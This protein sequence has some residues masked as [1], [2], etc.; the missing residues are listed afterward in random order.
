MNK[1]GLLAILVVF[2]LAVGGLWTT[3][4]VNDWE[5]QLGLD[6]QGG[7]SLTLE[8]APGQGEIDLEVLDQTVE[9]IRNRVDGLGVAEPEIARQGETVIVQ[10]PGVADQAQAEDIVQETAILQFRRV[11]RE[12]RPTDPDYD[13][14]GPSCAELEE[15]RLAG[16]P[17]A[18]EEVV[19]CQPPEAEAGLVD[20]PEEEASPTEEWTKFEL[21]P[22]V[23]DGGNVEDAS[24]R[25]GETGLEWATTLDF[26][27]EGEETFREFTAE[28]ACEQGDLR[29]LAIVLD[30][31]VESAPP[32]APEV[33]C[34]EG[35]A[36]GGQ[37]S[38]ASQQEAEDL[39]LVLRAGAL[40]IQLDLEQSLSVSPTLGAESLEAGLQAGLIGL[41]LVGAYL[42]VLYRGIGAAAVAELAMFGVIV[43]GALIVLGQTIGFTLTLAGIAG[44][45]V[46]IGIAADSSIIYRE[47]YRD[48]IRKGRTIRTAAEHAFSSA[49]ATNLT[50]NTVSFLAAA[51]LYILAVGPVR[52]FAFTLGLAT[53]I[54]TLLFAT[55]TRSL[56]GWIANTPKLARAKW[57]GL[58]AQTF[59]SK[60]VAKVQR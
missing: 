13:E 19:L 9:V 10:L 50:G 47:R 18:D 35:I 32:V 38:V 1:G 49:F 36:G 53:L 46:S 33:P 39:A 20:D 54:D 21:G 34:G 3:I 6:L 29:R 12:V 11:L 40:P 43:A 22:V 58:T 52:G 15:E 25:V 57:M 2:L 26:D 56:F 24:A 59:V 14:V 17:P 51:V 44:I 16:P 8:P 30:G 4:L 28:L 31:L 45:I 37:I 48:E 41:V 55:F 27:A 5:P 60:P 42:I 23:V 7:V